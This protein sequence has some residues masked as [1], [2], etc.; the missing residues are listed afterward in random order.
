MV[1]GGVLYK[2]DKEVKGHFIFIF[3]IFFFSFLDAPMAYGSS[4]AR[5]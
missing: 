1:E 5:D 4:Q 2:D 3:K